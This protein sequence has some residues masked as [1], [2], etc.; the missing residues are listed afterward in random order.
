M[1]RFFISSLTPEPWTTPPSRASILGLGAVLL[2][3]AYGMAV[4]GWVFLLD[5]ATLLI[6]EAGHPFL[7]SVSDRLMVYGGTIFQLAFPLAF[8]WHFMRH[9]Q[10][11]GYCFAL[12]WEAASIHNVGRYMSDARLQALPLVGNGDRIHDWHEIFERWG[13]LRHDVFIG[14]CASLLS[15]LLFGCCAY[16]LVRLFMADASR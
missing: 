2:V 12:A 14:G 13:L 4:P 6:H 11:L 9:D 16:M 10:A 1:L 7:G 8:C 15:W 3:I 5:N